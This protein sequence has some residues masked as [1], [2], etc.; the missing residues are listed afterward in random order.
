MES[1]NVNPLS[2][3]CSPTF[4]GVFTK[5]ALVQKED[6]RVFKN[7]VN[8][9][10]AKGAN[11]GTYADLK[12][13][14][15]VV[16]PEIQK[17]NCVVTQVWLGKQYIQVFMDLDSG[18]YI[19]AIAPIVLEGKTTQEI[20]SQITYYRR[21]MLLGLF[22]LAPEDGSDDDGNLAS[23]LQFPK[24]K[25]GELIDGK[26]KPWVNS[27]KAK[28]ENM[29]KMLSEGTLSLEAVYSKYKVSKED[30]AKLESVVKK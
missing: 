23:G 19:K 29:I 22:N 1:S 14:L 3:I 12:A 7:S 9:F 28:Y 16:L 25:N 11:K 24:P 30:Q 15:E 8:T 21:Y 26:E 5:L 18:E 27:D 10:L 20:G 17:H 13:N 2:E 4:L 6:L